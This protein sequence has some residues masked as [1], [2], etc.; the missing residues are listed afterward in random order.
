MIRPTEQIYA[1]YTAED[2]SVWKNL[3]ERQM[4]I[5]K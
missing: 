1:N 2:F 4:S 5:L 3:F